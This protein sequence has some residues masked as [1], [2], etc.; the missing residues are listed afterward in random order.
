M[1]R[2]RTIYVG[3]L[4]CGK[5]SRV[6]TLE[7]AH[8]WQERHWLACKRGALFAPASNGVTPR[9]KYEELEA[10]GEQ[11]PCCKCHGEPM[12]WER[13]PRLHEGGRWRCKRRLEDA[14]PAQRSEPA[15]S[16]RTAPETVALP[17]DTPKRD[18]A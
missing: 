3:C 16:P 1:I 6:E 7:G 8:A 2:P 4:P 18:R 12:R 9:Q 15:V 5:G 13:S 17:A 10:A 11:R 14:F